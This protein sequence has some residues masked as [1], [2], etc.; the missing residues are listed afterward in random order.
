MRFHGLTPVSF[1]LFLVLLPAA[2]AQN[3]TT[4]TIPLEDCYWHT[5]T[6]GVQ[7]PTNPDWLREAVQ[8]SITE[9]NT[10][11]EWFASKYF[12][13]SP[14]YHLTTTSPVVTFQVVDPN[15]L[16]GNHPALAY[17]YC[18]GARLVKVRIVVSSGLGNFVNLTLSSVIGQ[19]VTHEVGHALGLGH[20]AIPYD[21]MCGEDCVNAPSI[22]STL[23][24][25]ALHLLASNSIGS[26][27]AVTLPSN[28]PYAI[29][30]SNVP[31][32]E[33]PTDS[34]VLICALLSVFA[35]EMLRHREVKRC[36][37]A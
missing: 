13:G 26:S 37:P 10:A 7:V 36:R 16:S 24:L 2:F 18:S 5:L 32:A 11:Q 30:F 34:I 25:Y 3:A 31:I 27:L 6:V 15:Q 33:F 20:P 1:L 12:P 35:V 19:T 4:Y 22:P 23:D 8:Y 21:L 9:W 28:I 14:T 29:A 17:P